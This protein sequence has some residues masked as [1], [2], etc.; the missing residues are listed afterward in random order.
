[1]FIKI[2]S[3]KILMFDKKNPKSFNNLNSGNKQHVVAMRF[4]WT[5]YLMCLLGVSQSFTFFL[6]WK[7]CSTICNA[8]VFT[9]NSKFDNLSTWWIYVA[10]RMCKVDFPCGDIFSVICLLVVHTDTRLQRTAAFVHL[11]IHRNRT[12]MRRFSGQNLICSG[13]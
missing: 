4:H 7:C 9:L 2:A 8:I 11:K 10:L 5:R 13:I 3:K 12:A 1:M 6:L